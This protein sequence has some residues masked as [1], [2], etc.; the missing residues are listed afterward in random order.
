MTTTSDP[1]TRPSADPAFDFASDTEG[2]RRRPGP[3]RD[4]TVSPRVLVIVAWALPVGALGAGAAWVLLRLIGLITNV[5]FAGRIATDTVNPGAVGAPWWVILG[6]P[7]LGGVVVGLMARYGSEKIRGHGMPEAIEGVL[8]RRA[9]VEPKVAVLKPTSAAISIGTGGP[10]GAEGPIIMTGGAIGSIVAQR[11]AVTDDERRVLMVAG[12]ASG[13]AAVFNAPL[14]SVLLAVELLLF[15]WRP[16]SFL[17][18][19]AA[20]V[21]STILRGPMLGYAPIF[22]LD[23]ATW[24]ITAG[25]DVLCVVAGALGGLLAVAVTALVYASEDGFLHFGRRIHWMWWPAIGGLIIGVG[26]LIVPRALGVG[27]DVIGDLLSG[28]AALSLV[29]GILV[30]KSL[31]WGLSLGSGTSGGVLAPT[32]MIGAALGALE[33]FVLPSA[34]PGFWALVGLAA[35]VGGVMRSPLTGVV[36]SLELTHAWPALLPLLIASAAA[37]GVSVLILGRSVLT[38]K[39]ARRGRHLSREYTVDPLEYGFADEV[40]DPAPAVVK[41]GEPAPDLPERQRLFPVL[42]GERLVGVVGRGALRRDPVGWMAHVVTDPV[43]VGPHDTL[44]VVRDRLAAA[45]VTI[46][47]VAEDGRLLGLIGVDELLER[48]QAS[49]SAGARRARA[50]AGGTT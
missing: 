49:A 21:V 28:K 5:L 50:S 3:L 19:V 36:F 12:A 17:P 32:F 47:P 48:R 24:H 18:V 43:V 35:T 33:G 20:V 25:A 23:T 10:F 22:P 16:R 30:V 29:V 39:I 38:E 41:V 31:I 15:E 14:A 2:P 44:V 11:L 4:F 34:G 27:Y 45:G 6:A 9:V 13:M 7:V 26:G 1:D 46:A 8:F 42:D 37:Y 40:M